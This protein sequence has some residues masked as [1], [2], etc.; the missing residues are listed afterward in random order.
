MS[1]LTANDSVLHIYVDG[2][3]GDD[4]NDGSISSPLKTVAGVRA[5]LPFF[6][7]FT[8]Y[9]HFASGLYDWDATLGPMQLGARVYLIGDGAGVP[10]DD[11]FVT[12]LGSTAMA[13]GSTNKSVAGAG[14][15]V[16]AYHGKTLEVLSGAAQG[17]RRSIRNNTASVIVPSSALS[18]P[19]ATD[20]TFQIVE[21]GVRF[22]VP[23]GLSGTT[24]PVITA[25]MGVGGGGARPVQQ[26]NITGAPALYLVNVALEVST[27]LSFS[28]W[29]IL[30]SNVVF[31]GVEMRRSVSALGVF[32]SDYQSGIMAGYDALAESTS[33]VIGPYVDGLASSVTSWR[34]WGLTNPL[35]TSQCLLQP[36]RFTGVMCGQ[37]NIAIGGEW[38]LIGGSFICNANGLSTLVARGGAHVGLGEYLGSISVPFYIAN[39]SST[40]AKVSALKV[41]DLA[42]ANLFNALIEKTNVGTGIQAV[43]TGDHD[44]AA[45]GTIGIDGATGLVTVTGITG[46][47]APSYGLAVRGG[48]RINFISGYLTMSGWTVGTQ[49]AAF[50]QRLNQTPDMAQDLSLF[51]TDGDSIVALD[52]S[53]IQRF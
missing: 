45:P 43:G 13:A 3:N 48:G 40:D 18:A 28:I 5:H 42:S 33:K 44:S 26:R 49:A 20:D 1:D 32:A 17:D 35:S 47:N 4:A 46:T 36:A 24:T 2:T 9:V 7:K 52:G 19:P 11:G 14:W 39:A 37:N 51:V 22:K 25:I 23:A 30:S 53:R 12:L 21:P 15:S 27:P 34:G 16:N 50:S 10:G 41:Q 38:W 6:A 8:I 29:E 31:L